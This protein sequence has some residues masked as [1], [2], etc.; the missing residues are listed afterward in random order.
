MNIKQGNN[1]M[2]TEP[3]SK[4]NNIP[5]IFSVDKNYM[6]YLSVCITSI[7]DNISNNYNYD[8][9][10]LYRDVDKKTQE[11]IKQIAV[12]KKNVSI[13]FIDM[14]TTKLV[15]DD[16]FFTSNH[17]TVANY[18][19][20]FIPKL[21]PKYK[22]VLYLDCDIIV[23]TDIAKLY[24]TDLHG[25]TLGVVR[26]ACT[27]FDPSFWYKYCITKVGIKHPE[28]YFNSG[29]LVC[30]VQKMVQ[31][32]LTERCLERLKNFQPVCWD[33]CVLN[34]VLE[35]DVFYIDP[36]WNFQWHWMLEE[37][38]SKHPQKYIEHNFLESYLKSAETPFIIHYTSHVKA[39]HRWH[40]PM[41]KVW[42]QYAE[43][44]PFYDMIVQ[45]N[46]FTSTN[47]STYVPKEIKTSIIV[48]VYNVAPY[49]ATCLD[50][51]VNQTLKDIEIICVDDGST[52]G[53]LELLEKYAATDNRIVL[54][55]QP[56]SGQGT[57]RNHGLK[58]AR[59]KYIQF[60]D[61]DDFY[62]LDCCEKLYDIMENNDVE[63]TCFQPYVKYDAY[64]NRMG[65]DKAYFSLKYDGL[66]QMTSD[67]IRNIDVNCWNKIFRKSFLDKNKIRFPEKLHFE[68]VGFFWFWAT[69]A[70]NVFFLKQELM[71]Y[72]RRENSFV[73]NIFEKR[74]THLFDSMKVNELIYKWFQD[75]KIDQGFV[76]QFM[77][78]SLYKVFWLLNAIPESDINSKRHLLDLMSDFMAK[79]GHYIT[80]LQL[81]D[82]KLFND[83]VTKNYYRFKIGTVTDVCE[84]L[85]AFDKKNIPVIFAVDRNYVPYLSVAIQSIVDNASDDNNY[86]VIILHQ[87]LFEFQQ[88]MLLAT[89]GNK[90]NI[91][92][93]FV[94]MS[95][96]IREYS[97]TSLM[98]INHIT[99]AAY[100][101]LLAATIFSNYT[102][103]IYLDC[104]V[105][106]N[107]DIALLYNINIGNKS[108]AAV[109]DTVIAYNLDT[110]LL[111]D[112]LSQYLRDYL[113]VTDTSKY[114]NSGVIIINVEKWKKEHVENKLLLLAKQNHKYFHDQNILNSA[115][116]DDY[117]VLPPEWN[118]QYHVKFK[119]PK[120]RDVLG[121]DLLDLYDNIRAKPC[122][123]H[124]TSSE[125]PWASL[126][127][128]YSSDWWKYARRSPFY[129]IIIQK[130]N[131][132]T[133]IPR[134]ATN[135]MP[136]VNGNKLIIKIKYHIY[137]LLSHISSG[138]TRIK[139]LNKKNVYREKITKIRQIKK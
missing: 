74:S 133:A 27:Y 61:S 25:C 39:W 41:S 44:S 9:W 80:G 55:K 34:S 95:S 84:L 113:D 100:F 127:H 72:V 58:V 121:Q 67:M 101:R 106:V 122:L 134:K 36:R 71:C 32:N 63:V 53:S 138:K 131:G 48:P 99:T 64:S 111:K 29:V 66:Q 107:S 8:I 120:Y 6:P 88:R 136:G 81:S 1:N 56:N 123:I 97:L 98:N 85:P 83:I 54:L 132:N 117:Y 102:K 119:W 19:R 49:L 78:Y 14:T 118:F 20:I 94:H 7:L 51:L 70:N 76:E 23:N 37:F 24:E 93:R 42:W 69:M 112:G 13:R 115:F 129:E 60:L 130:L 30:D 135:P 46:K 21:F 91:S 105:I 68:D 12:K 103:V 82:Q 35:N 96:F 47:K 109:L 90:K 18:Y 33:Q 62:E 57:A 92:I 52:D 126:Y 104:D 116:H 65:E 50:S 5:V 10:V 3:F 125:K 28:N 89:V 77:I 26:D 86:D 110:V 2:N 16:Q 59:G 73:A 87:D 114:F 17:A 108:I 137:R 43:K 45:K 4:K 11:A 22:K 75:H 31:E 124:Y 139:Y 128:S 40:S 15:D 79:F 38:A